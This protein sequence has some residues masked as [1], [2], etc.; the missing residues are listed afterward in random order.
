MTVQ[1]TVTGSLKILKKNVNHYQARSEVVSGIISLWLLCIFIIICSALEL[2]RHEDTFW[3]D[4][5]L[6]QHSCIQLA[7]KGIL[8]NRVKNGSLAQTRRLIA[9][10]PFCFPSVSTFCNST[11]YST[12]RESSNTSEQRCWNLN[13]W[14]WRSESNKRGQDGFFRP[15]YAL[16]SCVWKSMSISTIHGV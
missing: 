16:Y 3:Q 2:L 14:H 9:F 5:N 12:L 11:F 13:A 15:I 4:L 10:L 7:S 6:H 1:S 8:K